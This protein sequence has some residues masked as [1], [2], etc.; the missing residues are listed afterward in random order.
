MTTTTTT[1]AAGTATIETL[2]SDENGR[3]GQLTTVLR[4]D[5]TEGAETEGHVSMETSVW[6]DGSREGQP[7]TDLQA[8]AAAA[9]AHF[10]AVA[11]N[12]AGRAE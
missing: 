9:A 11:A 2:C 12:L 7:Y 10:T 3:R 8:L 1:T 4:T 5:E 6:L